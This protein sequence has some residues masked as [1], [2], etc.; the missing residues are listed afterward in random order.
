VERR[1]VGEGHRDHRDGEVGAAERPGERVGA[2][3]LALV[4][5]DHRDGAGLLGVGRLD[6]EVAPSALDQRAT[7]PAVKPA[8]SAASQPAVDEPGV[9]PG[10]N[11]LSAT[12]WTGAVTSPLPE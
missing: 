9:G 1:G 12:S 7:L 5:D 3:G 2:A 4:E 10:G 11:W 6:R 8:K